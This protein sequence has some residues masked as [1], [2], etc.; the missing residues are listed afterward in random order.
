MVARARVRAGPPGL[1]DLLDPPGPWHDPGDRVGAAGTGHRRGLTGVDVSVVVVVDPD[2]PARKAG[3][4]GLTVL[5]VCVEVFEL[6]AGLGGRPPVAEVVAGERGP[7]GERLGVFA[8][9]RGNDPGHR[10]W[11]PWVGVRAGPP[12]GLDLS[13]VVGPRV[14]PC[15]LVVAVSIGQIGRLAD[16][17][18]VVA[19]VVDVDPPVLEAGLS[20][21]LDAVC[22]QVFELGARLGGR[23]PVAEVVARIRLVGR[24]RDRPSAGAHAGHALA[25]RVGRIGLGPARRHDLTD[26]VAARR[27]V[28]EGVV[29]APVG[30]GRGKQRGPRRVVEADRHS[31]DPKLTGVLDAVCVKVFELG[32][33]LGGSAPVAEV[34]PRVHLPRRELDR[35][36]VRS[37]AV[38]HGRHVTYAVVT[39]PARA[40]LGPTGLGHLAHYV[41]GAR[42]Q[43]REGV[44][45][46][47]VGDG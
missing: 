29:A 17:V 44:V 38:G 31:G 26:Q 16:V 23:G 10:I 6:D 4:S 2:R 3:L 1:G 32:A 20:G 15:D 46:A 18:G 40:R 24:E 21:V 39:R 43:V 28:R 9:R 8:V 14:D 12:G 27:E 42:D 7:R 47:P 33:R 19:V 36:A 30:G 35:V 22:V 25:G 37:Q 45:A 11:G 13:H 41:L 5:T 34:V